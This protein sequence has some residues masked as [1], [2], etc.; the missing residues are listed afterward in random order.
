MQ[1]IQIIG[2]NMQCIQ[3]IGWKKAM[4]SNNWMEEG[5]GFK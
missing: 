4:D 3:I 1:C 5:N 2:W